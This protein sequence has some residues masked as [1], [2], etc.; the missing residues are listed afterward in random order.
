MSCGSRS[1]PRLASGVRSSTTRPIPDLNLTSAVANHSAKNAIRSDFQN[2]HVAHVTIDGVHGHHADLVGN[3][4]PIDESNR[5]TVAA[6]HDHVAND[7]YQKAAD[8]GEALGG[9]GCLLQGTQLRRQLT[10]LAPSC[11]T[12]DDARDNAEGEGQSHVLVWVQGD[13]T[14][15][16]RQLR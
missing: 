9:R 7:V 8:R 2:Q 14:A 6:H 3:A 11:A 4:P 5:D 12:S 16:A 1:A 15:G 13:R 10:L